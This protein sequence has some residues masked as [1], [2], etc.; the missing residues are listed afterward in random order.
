MGVGVRESGEKA[1]L[2]LK[3]LNEWNHIVYFPDLISRAKQISSLS[4]NPFY[5]TQKSLI[6]TKKSLQAMWSSDWNQPQLI[7]ALHV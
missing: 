2:T 4:L 5:K 6:Q 1:T 7:D 3:L